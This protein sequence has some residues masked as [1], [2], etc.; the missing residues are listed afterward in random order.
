VIPAVRTFGVPSGGGGRMS[1]FDT[2][3]GL[4][5]SVQGSDAESTEPAFELACALARSA[6][7]L[8]AKDQ[9]IG[10][11]DATIADLRA[12]LA[13]AKTKI[14]PAR[15]AQLFGTGYVRFT[16]TGELWCLG[17]RETGWS[18]FGFRFNDWDELFRRFNVRVTGH[19]TDEHGE[20]WSV[21]N[22]EVAL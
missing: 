15:G 4:R 18:A 2:E 6:V 3:E 11:K 22:C 16:S 7:A 17:K 13:V 21:E 5:V 20:W 19:G 10:E 1:Q 8:A 14:A 12:Q 9:T